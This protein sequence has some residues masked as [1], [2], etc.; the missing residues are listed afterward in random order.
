MLLALLACVP[1]EASDVVLDPGTTVSEV[2]GAAWAFTTDGAPGTFS[3]GQV[4]LEPAPPEVFEVRIQWEALRDVA[5]S[6]EVILPGGF[7]LLRDG[8]FGFWE[9]N[10]QFADD[11]WSKAPSLDVGRRHEI[12]VRQKGRDVEV[13]HDGRVLA[14]HRFAARPEN[15]RVALGAK[16]PPSTRGRVL[17]RRI[18]MCRD[19][20]GRTAPVSRRPRGVPPPR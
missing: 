11:G 8:R 13:L 9:S 14:T 7:L 3:W 18:E 12:V 17:I 10:A 19:T 2:R 16:A 6:L 1:V 20:V 15:A 4:W 5:Y